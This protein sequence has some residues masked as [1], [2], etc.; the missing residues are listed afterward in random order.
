M[1]PRKITVSVIG[2]HKINK[3]QERLAYRVGQIIAQAGA[4]LVCGGLGGA[5]EAAAKGAREAGGLTVGILPGVSKAD[6]NPY[7]DI[8][9]PTSLGYARN[10]IVACSA[11]LIIALPGSDGTQS[12]ICYGL[13]YKRPVIDLGNW[14][15][16]GM[17]RIKSLE[18]LEQEIKKI[19]A[20]AADVAAN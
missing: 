18:N 9:L 6:A 19:K 7:I 10:V 14:N 17:S 5:M 2:G 13:I 12:E 20:M 8:P 11:D 15:K 16:S 4:V 1:I 3:S